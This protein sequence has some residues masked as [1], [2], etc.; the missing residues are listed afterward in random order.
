LIPLLVTAG[1]MG[2]FDIA[3][4]PSTAL[5]FSIVFG[6]AVDDSLHFLARFRQ[7]LLVFDFDRHK[8]IDVALRETGKSMIYTSI[9][10]FAGFIIFAFSSFGGTVA[11]GVLTSITLL[12]AMFTNLILLPALLLTFNANIRRSNHPIIEGTEQ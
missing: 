7:E 12:V 5:V 8:A 10:L 1:I 2:F 11:L 4:K 9:I 3:L 6:I